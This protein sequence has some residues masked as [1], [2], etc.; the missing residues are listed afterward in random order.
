MKVGMQVGLKH[1]ARYEYDD[2]DYDDVY[3]IQDISR[4]GCEV[5]LV[6]NRDE[7]SRDVWVLM[8][9]LEIIWAKR[10]LGVKKLNLPS[11]W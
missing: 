11:W 1:E 7:D 9:D 10:D 3:E 5:L 8:D 2:L 6:S 4:N